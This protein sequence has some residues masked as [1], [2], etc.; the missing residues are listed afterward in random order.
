MKLAIK[1]LKKLLEE[2][3]IPHIDLT[4]QFPMRQILYIPKGENEEICSIIQGLYSYGGKDN[5]LETKG[6]TKNGKENEEQVIGYLTAQEAFQIIN[7]HWR[8][9]NRKEK[10]C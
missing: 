10:L 1:E 5:L 2:A 8:K 3:D 7:K 6:L 4:E 9:Y